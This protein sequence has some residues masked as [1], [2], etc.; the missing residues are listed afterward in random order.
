[1]GLFS[2]F[3]A[4]ALAATASVAAQDFDV[5]EFTTNLEDSLSQY[6]TNGTSSSCLLHTNYFVR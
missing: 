5:D 3:A 1:M 2:K 6:D 4:L